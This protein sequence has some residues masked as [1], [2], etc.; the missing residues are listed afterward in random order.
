MKKLTPLIL[1]LFALPALCLAEER[2]LT[3]QDVLTGFPLCAISS[4]YGQRC[5]V[6]SDEEKAEFT[7]SKIEE[8]TDTEIDT[9]TL[10]VTTEDWFYSFSISSTE[11]NKA[12]LKFTDDANLATYHS[13]KKFDVQWNEKEQNWF[14]LGEITDYVSGNS[15]DKGKYTA[16]SEPIPFYLK[17]D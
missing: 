5:K 11:A 17:K 9:D 15:E 1:I 14:M 4:S 10:H 3:P 12:A 7:P 2:H 13:I 8:I 16:Y 6:F